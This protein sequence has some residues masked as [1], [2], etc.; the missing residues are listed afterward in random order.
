MS[1]PREE[2]LNMEKKIDEWENENISARGSVAQNLKDKIRENQEKLDKLVSI[3][4]DGDI[5]R[6]IYLE[7]KDILMREKASL[8]ESERDFGQQRKI[9]SNPC[10]VSFCP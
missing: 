10:G 7:R 1:L 3:Y 6:E 5:E 2:I 9:G 8:L 4:L